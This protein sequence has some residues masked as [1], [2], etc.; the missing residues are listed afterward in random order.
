MTEANPIESWANS[1]K[2]IESQKR[3][4]ALASL[5]T[6][7]EGSL[8]YLRSH[9]QFKV[10]DHF[11]DFTAFTRLL[12]FGRVSDDFINMSVLSL[13][14]GVRRGEFPTVRPGVVITTSLLAN[15][16]KNAHPIHKIA[17]QIFSRPETRYLLMP[18]FIEQSQ[19]WFALVID[20]ENEQ[21]LIGSFSF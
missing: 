16:M 18:V 13:M 8:D 21:I 19:H 7:V 3:I 11:F 12:S 15:C 10:Y 1:T 20:K 2:W 5:A 14:D 17:A 6:E 4:S 9:D